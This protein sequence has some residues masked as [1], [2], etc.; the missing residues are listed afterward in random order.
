M[1][2]HPSRVRYNELYHDKLSASQYHWAVTRPFTAEEIE[3]INQLILEDKIPRRKLPPRDCH[4][5]KCYYE[6]P[7][8]HGFA[9]DKTC[10]CGGH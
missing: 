7:H 3:V 2:H 10:S 5:L 1:Y 6:E 9:C 8:K 4:D